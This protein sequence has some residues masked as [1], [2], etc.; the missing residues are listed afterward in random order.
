MYWYI[1]DWD[2][3]KSCIF[4]LTAA[5]I[6]S[7]EK[8][9]SSR[10]L[11]QKNGRIAVRDRLG[12]DRWFS[13]STYEKKQ[14]GVS[15]LE[16]GRERNRNVRRWQERRERKRE[17]ERESASLLGGFPEVTV[18]NI[19]EECGMLNRCQGKHTDRATAAPNSRQG[20]L[21]IHTK[22]HKL[23]DIS[24]QKILFWTLP[25]HFDTLTIGFTAML[26]HTART[27][28]ETVDT[29]RRYHFGEI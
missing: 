29:C 28:A 4:S 6:W 26:A 27:L 22:T 10:D 1:K 8:A 23:A 24:V 15:D 19:T 16:E 12:I 14:G 18:L 7:C 9:A 3:V 20:L 13:M 21:Y 5:N 2:I 25:L 11:W 17:R